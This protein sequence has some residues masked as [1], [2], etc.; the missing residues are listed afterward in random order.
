MSPNLNHRI[1]SLK[2]A[3]SPNNPAGTSDKQEGVQLPKQWSNEM[4][5]QSNNVRQSNIVKKNNANAQKSGLPIISKLD[6]AG[7]SPNASSD[8]DM[9]LDDEDDLGALNF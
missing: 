9:N 5:R 1:R 4:Q 6:S 2:R 7:D 8:D 3:G